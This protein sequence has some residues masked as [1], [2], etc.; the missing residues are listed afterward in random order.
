[1]EKQIEASGFN[2]LNLSKNEQK[3]T[4]EAIIFAA[5][6]P[7]NLKS[8]FSILVT[9]EKFKSTKIKDEDGGLIRE[10]EGIKAKQKE[11]YEAINITYILDN[12]PELYNWANNCRLKYKNIIKEQEFL[13]EALEREDNVRE[14]IT[15]RAFGERG[16]N[17]QFYGKLRNNIKITS[18]YC[19]KGWIDFIEETGI[20]TVLHN[21]GYTKI[22]VSNGNQFWVLEWE[23][24]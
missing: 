17:V 13:E 20:D 14:I 19:E 6:E 10:S 12:S 15:K 2:F 11:Y 7:I 16:K 4:L 18:L 5:E 3:S 23:A 24:N 8:L 22:V 1:M 9:G 21:L